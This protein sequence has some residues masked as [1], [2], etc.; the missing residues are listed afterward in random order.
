MNPLTNRS[1]SQKMVVRWYLFSTF[2]QLI[3]GMF[4]SIVLF[5]KDSMLYTFLDCFSNAK[6]NFSV[7]V[8]SVYLLMNGNNAR[9]D[10]LR[11]AISRPSRCYYEMGWRSSIGWGWPR[12][13][14]W[15]ANDWKHWLLLAVKFSGMLSE[16]RDQ[17]LELSSGATD[18]TG[19]M[20][21]N[22]CKTLLSLV[23]P[24]QPCRFPVHGVFWFCAF[25][26]L[27]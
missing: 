6:K 24:Y 27:D 9:A 1:C 11:L 19:T 7:L 3:N 12:S 13:V 17:M 8:S 21:S 4:F 14:S 5:G 2:L 26:R 22:R 16:T 20:D 15:I 25:T 23:I 18:S 10:I